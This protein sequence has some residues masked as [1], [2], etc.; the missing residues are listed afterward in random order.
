MSSSPAEDFWRQPHGSSWVAHYAASAAAPSR[1]VLQAVLHSLAP[2]T[3]VVDLGCNCGVLMPLLQAASP[4]VQVVG[5][6]VSMEALA[7]AKRRYPAQTWVFASVTYWLPVLADTGSHA[8]IVVS[9]SCLEHVA[10]RDIDET[11]RA[12]VRVATRA[13]VLQEVTTT[14]RHPEGPSIACGVPEWRHDYER[15]LSALGWHRTQK[16]W[17]NV[18]SDRPGA[19]MVFEP[20][21]GYR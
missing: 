10:A 13:V 16:F 6:D 21:A 3:T 4:D 5:I 15:R 11:L 20:E 2:F 12:L 7:A 19:V 9:S 8:D 14:P 18:T 17:Q 1:A